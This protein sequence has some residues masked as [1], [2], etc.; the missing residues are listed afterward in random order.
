MT[1]SLGYGAALFI[2]LAGAAHAQLAAPA[3]RCEEDR[4]GGEPP[5]I[6]S[7]FDLKEPGQGGIAFADARARALAYCARQACTIEGKAMP[8]SASIYAV[9]QL[10]RRYIAG[11]RCVPETAPAPPAPP[12]SVRLQDPSEI[13][14]ARNEAETRCSAAQ[15]HAE[16]ADLRRQEGGLLAVFACGS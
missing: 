10:H 8:R 14:R 13:D 12:L 7:R 15:G 6:S 3:A 2:L 4:A 1:R 16:L 11:F 9:G 5:T